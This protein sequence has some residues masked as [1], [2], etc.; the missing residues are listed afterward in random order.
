MVWDYHTYY[1]QVIMNAYTK[2]Q[3]D[4]KG[5]WAEL[6]ERRSKKGRN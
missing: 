3:I 4:N 1:K 5:K 2:H 6:V